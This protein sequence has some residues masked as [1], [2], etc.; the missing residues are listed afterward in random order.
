[1]QG[2]EFLEFSSRVYELRGNCI[3]RGVK[4]LLSKHSRILKCHI[5]SSSYENIPQQR[6]SENLTSPS[7][8]GIT[9]RYHTAYRTT[10]TKFR[11]RLFSIVP[12]AASSLY[13]VHPL[14]SVRTIIFMFIIHL[15]IISVE[16]SVTYKF[17]SPRWKGVAILSISSAKDNNNQL[18]WPWKFPV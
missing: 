10:C 7:W 17:F 1:M 14:R 15:D 12:G 16:S 8:H 2:G 11:G 18:Y 4:S 5:V 6:T 9:R 3:R 13:R